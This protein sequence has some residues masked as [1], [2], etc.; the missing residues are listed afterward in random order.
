[1]NTNKDDKIVLSL[2]TRH[3]KPGDGLLWTSKMIARHTELTPER[4]RKALNRLV[5]LGLIEE[6]DGAYRVSIRM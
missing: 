4:A 1:M 2:L 6:D 5:K 3:Q